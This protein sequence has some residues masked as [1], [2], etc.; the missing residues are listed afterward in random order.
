MA[1]INS[2][3]SLIAPILLMQTTGPTSLPCA[4]P[5]DELYSREM[6]GARIV[7]VHESIVRENR[8]PI[9]RARAPFTRAPLYVLRLYPE[10]KEPPRVLWQIAGLPLVG[11]ITPNLEPQ[12]LDVCVEL[13]H[14]IV[15]FNLY[16]QCWA[17]VVS[18][19]LDGVAITVP[20]GPIRTWRSKGDL[21]SA[22][23]SA[24]ITGSLAEGTLRIVTV[25][26]TGLT[27][28]FKLTGNDDDGE[29]S[30]TEP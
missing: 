16:G 20:R 25:D 30:T 11:I 12:M 23:L 7:L 9:T 2:L 22:K 19:I 4:E 29:W 24:R 17:R 18:G 10:G 21:G 26:E 3:I 1:I 6:E 27:T 15:V 8:D 28:V 13:E 14:T 5:E